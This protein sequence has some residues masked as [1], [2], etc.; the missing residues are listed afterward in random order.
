MPPGS[1]A[2]AEQWP[3]VLGEIIRL[4][5]QQPRGSPSAPRVSSEAV[6]DLWGWKWCLSAIKAQ[7]LGEPASPGISEGSL[8]EQ[9]GRKWAG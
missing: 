4:C 8:A 7:D 9:A 5:A 6:A 2:K 1:S 3:F